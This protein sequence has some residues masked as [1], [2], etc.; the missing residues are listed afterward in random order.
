MNV[1]YI[2]IILVC[3]VMSAFFSA[4]ETA[5][6]SANKT[7]LKTMG[8]KGNDRARLT[9]RL[10]E[11]YDKLISTIL[12]GNN[13]VNILASSLATIVF[14]KLYGDVGA[15]I[16][17]AVITVV[18]LLFGE[19]SPKSI[20]KET[21]ERFAMF[22]APILKGMIWLLTPVNAFFSGW[23]AMLAK[24]LKVQADNRM[25]Q[26]EL[27][28]FVEEVEQGGS[29]DANAGALLRNAIEF[30]DREVMEILTHRVDLVAV[31]VT[32][33]KEEMAAA[34]ADSMF[35]RLPVYEGS[36]DNIVGV[37]HQKDFYTGA[38]ISGKSLTELMTAPVFVPKGERIS[39]LLRILQQAK[40]HVAVVVDEYGGTFG[41]VT[42]E[43]ILEELVGEIWDEHDDVVEH[44]RRLENGSF[45]VDGIMELE[46]FASYFGIRTESTMVSV[47]GWLMEELG[48]LPENGDTVEVDGCVIR[49]TAVENHRVTSLTVTK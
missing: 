23:K 16:S 21:P 1:F 11:Q 44:I 9:L 38:G 30:T 45:A 32:A 46:D 6:S 43:D 27:L 41:I 35:S 40:S 42:M 17:T 31:S 2:A 3:I 8:E 24:L 39:R 4:S 18:V 10:A 14:V 25:S 15:T 33:S 7:R 36:I 13:I 20:A 48:R 19:I 22:A 49:V 47:G 29:I 26:E 12:I 37:V 5:F 34:F 28:M